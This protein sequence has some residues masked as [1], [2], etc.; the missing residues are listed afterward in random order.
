MGALAR[1]EP[2]TGFEADLLW[3]S[4][5]A[6]PLEEVWSRFATEDV[7]V[8][9]LKAMQPGDAAFHPLVADRGGQKSVVVFSSLTRAASAHQFAEHVVRLRGEQ[10]ILRTPVG[11][12][13]LINPGFEAQ[14]LMP[15]EVVAQIASQLRAQRVQ[16]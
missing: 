9:S 13:L 6:L 3:G 4:Q 16:A 10:L 11:M 14:L 7:F 15:A 8:S 1:F 12:G 2:E 5:D